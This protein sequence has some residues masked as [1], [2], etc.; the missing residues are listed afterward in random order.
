MGWLSCDSTEYPDAD[1]KDGLGIL[2]RCLI[3]Q[4]GYATVRLD[5]PGV[6]ESQGDCAKADFAEELSGYQ[7][8]L[9][10]Y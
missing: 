6:G 4:S 8:L 7:S 5:K 1:T 3:E 9:M 2:L 10:K